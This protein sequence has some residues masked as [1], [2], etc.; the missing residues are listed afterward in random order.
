MKSGL[1]AT[2]IRWRRCFRPLPE[3]FPRGRRARKRAGQNKIC[4]ALP[5]R[6]RVSQPAAKLFELKRRAGE[7]RPARRLRLCRDETARLSGAK[8]NAPKFQKSVQAAKQF[9]KARR[10]D[11]R[12]IV[13]SVFRSI[14]PS[15][16]EGNEVNAAFDRTFTALCESK[17]I[18]VNVATKALGRVSL[19]LLMRARQ[20]F[21]A[22]RISK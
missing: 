17:E 10:C 9:R 22:G 19:M 12:H 18:Q 21:K 16:M 1:R 11:S 8:P 13:H 20:K 6:R 5:F 2:C 3:N 4:P 14:E 7:R 15:Q